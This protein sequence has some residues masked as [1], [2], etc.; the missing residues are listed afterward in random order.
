MDL[1]KL[2]R[3]L[4]YE[5]DLATFFQNSAIYYQETETLPSDF[6]AK[7]IKVALAVSDQQEGQQPK[8]NDPIYQ[9]AYQLAQSI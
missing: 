8:S 5:T 2:V 3:Y 9:Q 6:E 4:K 1:E 7:K